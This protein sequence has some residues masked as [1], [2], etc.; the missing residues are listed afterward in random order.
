MHQNSEFQDDGI[1]LSP[2]LLSPDGANGA[3]PISPGKRANSPSSGHLSTSV[4]NRSL[5]ETFDIKPIMSKDDISLLPNSN[6]PSV[7]RP[8]QNRPKA[9]INPFDPSHVTIKLTS[10][11]R[12][13]THV[14][15]L[16]A[17]GIF[18][19]Q[20]HYQ[21]V[22][23]NTACTM[24]PS[25]ACVGSDKEENRKI[26]TSQIRSSDH[27][28]ASS[29][30]RQ[31]KTSPRTSSV[32]E[33]RTVHRS[34]VRGLPEPAP[35]SS[36]TY[37]WGATGEQEWTPAI[38]TGVD[39]KS[40][41]VPACLPIT[42]DFF[43]DKRSLTN[44]YVMT[45]Y[46]LLPEDQGAELLNRVCYRGEEDLRNHIPILT[47]Q[48]LEELTCQ[49]L[50]QGFQLIIFPK[51][52]KGFASKSS[53]DNSCNLGNTEYIMS[54]GRIFHRLQLIDN[55]TIQ[56]TQY[57]PRHPYPTIEIHYC[58]RFR[59]PDNK[60]FGVSWVDF[61]S[62]RLENYNWNYLDNYIC[63]R[64][65]E[66]YALRDEL[67]FW[68]FRL[69]VLPNICQNITKRILEN[70]NP[71]GEA[72]LR[73]LGAYRESTH[74]DRIK[75]F[76]GFLKFVELISKIK[77]DPPKRGRQQHN[78]GRAPTS[79]NLEPKSRNPS[80]TQMAKSP[81][82]KNF[83][84][85]E[86]STLQSLEQSCCHFVGNRADEKVPLPKL[87]E[88]AERM[89]ADS[90]INFMMNQKGLQPKSFISAEAIFWMVQTYKEIKNEAQAVRIFQKMIDEKLICHCS[91]KTT[92][93]FISGF[94]L[95]FIVTDPFRND[96]VD[97]DMY[98]S[99]WL[100]IEMCLKELSNLDDGG[101]S[102][103]WQH[104]FNKSLS[105]DSVTID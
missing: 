63:L 85:S 41:V 105:D 44:D 34:S 98:Q 27:P 58:Y 22:P 100:E 67:K 51:G 84:E 90:T 47:Q 79:P 23:Q 53:S 94:Y 3:I 62:D 69:L 93:P 7:G 101:P 10:N 32:T 8:N 60:N 2:N 39:W 91:R 19:Q 57:K 1:H 96:D 87:E 21:A 78:S 36:L 14:F 4:E 102:N 28:W 42:T 68:R 89:S 82:F 37:A 74:E 13:W 46:S 80:G 86:A 33:D 88:I 73:C 54:I 77:R 5:K 71:A 16:G 31:S 49:R 48:V 66:E 97:L 61:T 35:D 40:L 104:N 50:Q 75:L 76:Q 59:A 38:T 18:M 92:F 25:E 24:L 52:F 95:Y 6:I 26:A 64:G 30:A 9:L 56:V 103:P 72:Q 29:Q 81:R 15:P 17:T 43:P 20:H 70:V 65:D 55:K 99:D 11:R 83:D 45:S 12:R